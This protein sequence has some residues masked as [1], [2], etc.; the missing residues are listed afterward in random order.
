MLFD[1]TFVILDQ[2]KRQIFALNI[3][4]IRDRRHANQS[5]QTSLDG[6]N[7]APPI[8]V[9]SRPRDLMFF[10]GKSRKIL[11]SRAI[12]IENVNI[13]V[14]MHHCFAFDRHFRMK[15]DA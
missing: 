11:S 13:V 10:I 12:V 6:F 9:A 8:G 14:N 1:C 5:K 7:V 15:I 4:A 3:M 2:P